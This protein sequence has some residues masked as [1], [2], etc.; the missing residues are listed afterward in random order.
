M[1]KMIMNDYRMDFKQRLKALEQPVAYYIW[2][3]VY[4]FWIPVMQWDKGNSPI[5]FVYVIHYGILFLLVDIGTV[6]GILYPN[7]LGKMFYLIPVSVQEKK[8]YLFTAYLFRVFAPLIAV[9]TDL[10]LLIVTDLM[11]WQIAIFMWIVLFVLYCLNATAYR[12]KANDIRGQSKPEGAMEGVYWTGMV[13][14]IILFFVCWMYRSFLASDYSEKFL[15][16][17]M[18][19]TFVVQMICSV[20]VVWRFWKQKWKELE[21][22]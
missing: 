1:L 20:V 8:R 2:M 3:M 17:V 22:L 11:Q 6:F 5:D 14:G 21:E 7:Q 18:I 12:G 9:G 4:G 19:Y 13:A 16:L 15:V 10:I